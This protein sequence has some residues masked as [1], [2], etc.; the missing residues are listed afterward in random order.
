MKN[1][2]II[3]HCARCGKDREIAKAKEVILRKRCGWT[4]K[5]I[6]GVCPVCGGPMGTI[7][8]PTTEEKTPETQKK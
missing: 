5:F 2:T 8:F 7:I 4:R 3:D 6:K 1:K